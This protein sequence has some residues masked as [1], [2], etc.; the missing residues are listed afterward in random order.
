MNS[1]ATVTEFET[2]HVDM[3]HDIAY[4]Y[5]GKRLA[6]CSSDRT[7]KIFDIMGDQVS[8][9]C[10]LSDLGPLRG[11]LSCRVSIRRFEKPFL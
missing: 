5:Y 6:T 4:D 11:A 8:D 2:G 3:V 10:L 9:L 7:I 1:T